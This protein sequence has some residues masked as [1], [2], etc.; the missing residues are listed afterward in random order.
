MS[1]F[2]EAFLRMTFD[3]QPANHRDPA[4]TIDISIGDT[5]LRY[6]RDAD[7]PRTTGRP[8]HPTVASSTRLVVGVAVR[9][10]RDRVNKPRFPNLAVSAT[11]SRPADDMSN[12]VLSLMRGAKATTGMRAGIVDT[13]PGYFS[14]SSHHPLHQLTAALG[15]TPCADY[16]SRFLGG[17][18]PT[19]GSPFIESP[20]FVEGRAYC[21]AIPSSLVTASIDRRS[22]AIDE[23][24]YRSRIRE[25]T[26]FEMRVVG[27]VR[28]DGL[29]RMACST[30][31]PAHGGGTRPRYSLLASTV[32]IVAQSRAFG[33]RS[34]EWD[35][36]H[37]LARATAETFVTGLASSYRHGL[38]QRAGGLAAAQV[39]LTMLLTIQNLRQIERFSAEQSA[40]VSR[41]VLRSDA[42]IRP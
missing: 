11:V 17:R 30:R 33:Y 15:F 6:E 8:I 36:F 5:S 19:A 23:Q 34:A 26:G 35:R 7:R 41:R 18:R 20:V 10:D 24:T 27:K 14:R 21:S 28:K 31:C 40:E 4:A 32:D 25:R 3:T 9:V 39:E 1:E 13:D 37:A 12:H 29:V 38:L 42:R 2:T 22:S 16:P